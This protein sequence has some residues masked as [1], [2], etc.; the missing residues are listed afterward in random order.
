MINLTLA[1]LVKVFRLSLVPLL[2]I[3]KGRKD[4]QNK[5]LKDAV[6]R[7]SNR[8]RTND[9]VRKRL[10]TWKDRQAKRE[11]RFPWKSD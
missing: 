5:A 9:D 10:L 7:L 11:R 2:M 1:F 3:S 6:A 8:P 4:E